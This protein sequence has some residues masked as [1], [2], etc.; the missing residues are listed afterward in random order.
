MRA[1]LRR[2]TVKAGQMDDFLN[3]WEH[4]VVPVRELYGFTVLAAWRSEDDTQFGWVV[5]YRGEGQ[6]ETAEKAYY[7]SPERASLPD[8]VAQYLTEVDT[9]M[10]ETV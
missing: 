6:F 4:G 2:Y 8:D 3:A 5:G 7:G 10:V 9:T 1:Q